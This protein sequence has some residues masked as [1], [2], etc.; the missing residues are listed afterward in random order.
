MSGRRSSQVAGNSTYAGASAALVA[1]VVLVGYIITAVRED[2]S[3]RLS[4]EAKE[5]KSD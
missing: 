3:E 2:Q 4:E 5:K 1:N